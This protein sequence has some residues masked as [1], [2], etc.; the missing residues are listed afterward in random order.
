MIKCYI[1]N[2]AKNDQI[3]RIVLQGHDHDYDIR[4]VRLY[5]LQFILF[6]DVE[7]KSPTILHDA[8]AII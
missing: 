7:K 1:N 8:K 3:I 2:L 6:Y 5:Y 4:K